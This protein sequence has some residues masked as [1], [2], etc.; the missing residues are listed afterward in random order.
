MLDTEYMW[1][2]FRGGTELLLKPICKQIHSTLKTE[3]SKYLQVFQ[4][5]ILKN[6]ALY[7]NIFIKLVT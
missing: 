4:R 6:T 2:D 3:V 1:G 7:T 5:A